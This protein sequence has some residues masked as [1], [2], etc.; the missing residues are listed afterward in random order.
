MRLA[1]I[2]APTAAASAFLNNTPI[3]AMV[4]P[5]VAA[6]ARRRG[7]APS[8]FLMP[9]SYATVL[10]GVITV[11]GTSTNVVIVGLMDA[12][13]QEPL[14]LFELAKAGLP[15]AFV[16]VLCIIAIAPKVLPDRWGASGDLS[17]PREFTV[18][19][20]VTDP[21]PL[22]GRS[23]ADAGLRNLEA[24][25]LVELERDGRVRAPVDPE[26]VLEP[27]DR[28]TFAGNVGR[29]ID[30]QRL[31]GLAMA[32]ER[33]FAP[34]GGDGGP[35]FLQ[36]VVAPGSDLVG[37]TLKEVGF[38]GRYG[39]AI[40][41]VH[42]AAERVP[43]KLGE[44]E[45]RAGDVLL[46]V[47]PPGLIDRWHDSQDFLLVS[48]LSGSVPVRRKRVWVVAL[49]AVGLVTTVGFGVLGFLEA[50]LLAAGALVVLR[51]L[52][53]AE[54]REAIDL[55]VIVLI[56]A[57]FGVGEAISSS[58]LASTIASGIVFALQG[59][60][61]LGVL[62]GV[63]LATMALTELIANN[64]AAVL[65]FPIA[66]AVSSQH[67][68]NPRS[69]AVAVAIGASASFLAPI[70]YQTNM[71]VYGMGGYRFSDFS[72]LGAPITVTSFLVALLTIPFGWPLR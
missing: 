16:G 68:I 49:V 17:D 71:M 23:V 3:V 12:A 45:L 33:H 18:E 41:A 48:P 8:R 53:P 52:S 50:A 34:A 42:R 27:G 65:M 60:G 58:G 9:I 21:S 59:F 51:V 70:G 62:A 61:D 28:L 25:F 24:V 13:G 1:R 36:A 35:R 10:G 64:A 26:E 39:A 54:A 56:A 4:A 57:S 43:G 30:L 37:R 38:R 46:A 67:G 15:I 69:L 22:A 11:M 32:E 2:I 44:V 72:R 7:V 55:N 6:W 40:V 31:P 29:V 63:L 66:M 20:V 19:M 47:G 5:R 14:G